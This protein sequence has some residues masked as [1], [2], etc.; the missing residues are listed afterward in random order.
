M[1]DPH[2]RQGTICSPGVCVGG[3]VSVTLTLAQKAHKH[4]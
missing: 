2:S 1:N 4:Y 3:G